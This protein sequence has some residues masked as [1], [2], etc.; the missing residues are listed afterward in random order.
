MTSLAE[1]VLHVNATTTG[2]RVQLTWPETYAG[3]LISTT[4]PGLKLL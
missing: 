2:I 4:S 3:D 1:I